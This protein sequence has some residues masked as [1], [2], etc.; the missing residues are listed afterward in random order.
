M[1]TSGDVKVEVDADLR[2]RI[3]PE[4]V[5]L[6]PI[7]AQHAARFH[8]LRVDLRHRLRR[9][10]DG[11]V[12]EADDPQV[13]KAAA[14]RREVQLRQPVPTAEQVVTSVALEVLGASLG[15]LGVESRNS[16]RLA[17]ALIIA[18]VVPPAR[19]DVSAGGYQLT[20][21]Q[22]AGPVAREEQPVP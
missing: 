19:P 4:N 14:R 3:A 18:H 1:G 22:A 17:P 11:A 7:G 12:E 5:H 6:A 2:P 13:E 9:A 15:K 20:L 16:E 10:P 21:R 8:E